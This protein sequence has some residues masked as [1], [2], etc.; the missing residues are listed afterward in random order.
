MK[1]IIIISMLAIIGLSVCMPVGKV[2]AQS[3]TDSLLLYYKFNSNALDSSGNGYDGTVYGA[4]LTTDR[5]GNANSAYS[6][7]GNCATDAYIDLPN[8]SRLKP[9]LPFSFSLWVY[10]YNLEHTQLFTTDYY[11]PEYTGCWISLTNGP[12]PGDTVVGIVYGDGG[13]AGACI[14]KKMQNWYD[15]Y[16]QESMV[17]YNWSIQ[18]ANRYGYLY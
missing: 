7:N 13:A 14:F 11:V 18:R 12:S 10:F 16:Y 9:Q 17:S 8:E 15:K 4:T 6:F 2:K 5:F 3:L 1:K